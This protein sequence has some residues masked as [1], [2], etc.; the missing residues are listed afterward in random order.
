MG[1][2]NLKLDG[3]LIE[4]LAKEGNL[5]ASQLSTLGQKAGLL[6]T[7][8]EVNSSLYK[9]QLRGSVRCTTLD[10]GKKP[11]WSIADVS[12]KSD[13]LADRLYRLVV[14]NPGKRVNLAEFVANL[15]EEFKHP[16][17]AVVRRIADAANKK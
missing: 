1:A 13:P 17:A 16:K 14:A 10:G 7:K 15:L 9:L 2:A 5:S 12:D 4:L 6:V 3:L 11:R 8:T